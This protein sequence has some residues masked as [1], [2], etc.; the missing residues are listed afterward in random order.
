M[1]LSVLVHQ[2]DRHFFRRSFNDSQRL[3]VGWRTVGPLDH[4]STITVLLPIWT[5][6]GKSLKNRTAAVVY[7]TEMR[8]W[9]RL[10]VGSVLSFRNSSAFLAGNFPWTK[11][12]YSGNSPVRHGH[13][14][15]EVSGT[16]SLYSYLK[17]QVWLKNDIRY[18]KRTASVKFNLQTRF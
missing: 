8:I 10:L 6:D 16:L 9:F 17:L 14:G 1:E 15:L 13:R 18:C 12:S 4:T 7:R 11:C 3:P 2:S 5:K